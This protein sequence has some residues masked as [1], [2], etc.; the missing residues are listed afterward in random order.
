MK[1]L[2]IGALVGGLILFIWQFL[3]YG[4]LDL[5]YPQMAHT[6]H[7][8]EIMD[9]LNNQEMVEGEYF[10]PRPSKESTVDHQE[11]QQKNLGKPWAIIQYHDSMD[12]SFISNLIRA[13]ITNSLAVGILCWFLLQYADLTMRLAIFSAI[14]VGLITY[15]TANYLDTIWFKTDSIPDLID[16]IIPWALI[17]CWLGWWLRRSE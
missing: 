1:K 7:Q 16:A 17:G 12:E 6:P 5:H 14:G 3:S 15:F 2:I 13:L 9:F 8:S 10:L 11:Y 4:L